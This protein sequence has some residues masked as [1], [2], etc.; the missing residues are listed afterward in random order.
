[1]PLAREADRPDGSDEAAVTYL[2]LRLGMVGMVVLLVISVLIEHLRS[3][4]CWQTSLSAYFHTPVHSV[5][6]GGLVSI[7]FCLVVIRGRDT[8]QDVFLNVAGML[9]PVVALV[10]TSDSGSCHSTPRG[11]A[12]GTDAAPSV[13]NAFDLA[14]VQNNL[15]ALFFTG[16]VALLVSHLWRRRL[17]RGSRADRIY[18]ISASFAVTSGLVLVG[19]AL[20]VFTDWFER[21]AHGTAAIAMFGCLG[22]VVFIRWRASRFTPFGF[23][24]R[25]IWQGM[26]ACALLAVGVGLLDGREVIS[27]DHVVLLVEAAEIGWFVAFWITRAIEDRADDH[28]QPL[29]ARSA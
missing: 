5:F 11:P 6:V 19:F 1:M 3:P 14:G 18:R 27:M 12:Q 10:P 28:Q 29:E 20:F 22:V 24:Y 15:V 2:Y 9:A 17:G 8:W 4:S 25:V 7:G 16:L 21:V 26:A 13:L 23:T